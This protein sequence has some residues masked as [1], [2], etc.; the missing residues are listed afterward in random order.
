LL[1]QS[2]MAMPALKE[3]GPVLIEISEKDFSFLE[4]KP[5]LCM[6]NEEYL[7]NHK[8]RQ[9]LLLLHDKRGKFDPSRRELI[10]ATTR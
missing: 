5:N 3:N 4:V 7:K 6:I 9:P 8:N 10:V 1:N 2:W